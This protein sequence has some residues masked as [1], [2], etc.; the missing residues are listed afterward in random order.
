MGATTASRS[1]P[2]FKG[3]PGLGPLVA[4]RRNSIQT[5]MNG[6]RECG[7][8]YRFDG[9]LPIHII[10]HP[11]ALQRILD[12]NAGNYEHPAPFS[13]RLASVMGKGLITSEG[14]SW[15]W[16]RKLIMP[17]FYKEAIR[18]YAASMV[19]SILAMAETWEAAAN[20]GEI[21]DI[22]KEMTSLTLTILAKCLFRADFSRDAQAIGDS[23]QAQLQYVGWKMRMNPLDVPQSLPIARNK[24]F[25]AEGQRMDDIIYRLITERRRAPEESD[26]MLSLF[27][28]VRDE[29]TGEGMS[30][31]QVRDE[32]M[33]LF[34]AG[35][36][37][38][39]SALTWAF[40]LLSKNPEAG[41][42]LRA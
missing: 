13:K 20:R 14:R 25:L 41:R 4:F 15:F 3:L 38:T 19:E 30:D 39:A 23:V 21:L 26:D 16:Q 28:Q 5:I 6:W 12:D 11:D 31:E 7:D 18:S 9:P 37:T 17:A 2:V 27:L 40:Y 34:I 10:S 22:R 36:D 1:V 35:H 8:I 24:R 32:I 33:T 29:E 42:K